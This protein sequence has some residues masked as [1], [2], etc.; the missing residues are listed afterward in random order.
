MTDLTQQLYLIADEIRGMASIQKH[1]SNNIYEIERAHRMMDLAAQIAALAD[2]RP[3]S[4]VKAIFEQQPWLRV[5]P[6]VGVDAFVL[7]EVGEVLLIQRA[8]NQH[9]A[10][11]GGLAEIGRTFAETAVLELWE[12]AG[13]Q[14]RVERLLGVFDGRMWGS[15]AKVHIINMTFL[16]HCDDLKP[17]PGLEALVAQFFA[18]DSLPEPLH[19][20]H[21]QRIPKCFELLDQD[22]YFDP[23]AAETLTLPMHQRD[24]SGDK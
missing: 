23:A 1:F 4:E 13:M 17:V 21:D 9:W 20:G 5:S 8:D 24:N 11:P 7:N 2:E 16:V 12:E 6:A 15:R 14:G 3:L 22:A 19:P 18:R 10:T